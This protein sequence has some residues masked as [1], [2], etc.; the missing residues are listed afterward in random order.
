MVGSLPMPSWRADHLFGFKV[1]GWLAETLRN[2]ERL[3]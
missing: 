1:A 3:L 2:Q